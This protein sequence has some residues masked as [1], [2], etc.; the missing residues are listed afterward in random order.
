MQSARSARAWFFVVLW[1]ALVANPLR[2]APAPSPAALSP[3][4][5]YALTTANHLIRF[6]STAPGVILGNVTITGLQAG[7]T[8]LAIDFRPYTHA[9][10]ALGSTSR[11]YHINRVTGV[12][13]QIGSGPF[14]PALNGTEF[15]FDFNPVVDRVRV[16][17]D[18]DQ[19]LRLDPSLGTVAATDTPVA[20]AAGDVYAGTNAVVGGLAYSNNV[21]SPTVT[22]LFGYEAVHNVLVT[23]GGPN[24]VPSSNGGQLFTVGSS[25]VVACNTLIGMDIASSGQAYASLNT[26]ACTSSALY[27]VNLSTGA[28]TLVGGIGGGVLIRDIAVQLEYLLYLPL[29][30][31]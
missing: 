24:G 16:V 4:M 11:L 12:A 7:E 14:T 30:R 18:T 2:A 20:F 3:D 17:S 26:G 25:G 15:A 31:R 6:R 19:N 21:L 8:L 23:Q 22:T 1:S 29:I 27:T 9:L 28:A 10:Y 13:T 5:I